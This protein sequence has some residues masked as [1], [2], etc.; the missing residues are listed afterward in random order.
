MP[1]NANQ[2]VKDKHPLSQYNEFGS[3]ATWVLLH[4]HTLV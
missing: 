4:A 2:I 3:N 1:E